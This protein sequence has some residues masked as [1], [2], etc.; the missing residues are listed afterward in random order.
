MAS[1]AASAEGEE[2]VDIFHDHFRFRQ[3]GNGTPAGR[4]EIPGVT[5]RGLR[6][7]TAALPTTPRTCQTPVMATDGLVPGTGFAPCFPVRDM[8]AALAHYEQLGFNV[9]PYA[10]GMTWGWARLGPAE[11]HLFVNGDHDPAT[12]AAAADLTVENADE[13]CRALRQTAADGTSDPYDTPYGRE[14]VHVDPDNNLMR[15]ITPAAR[16]EAANT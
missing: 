1:G 12:T 5:A 2:P 9:M 15:F 3:P 10:D 13:L 14:F 7:G 11:L 4:Q 16:A 6:P 8:Q